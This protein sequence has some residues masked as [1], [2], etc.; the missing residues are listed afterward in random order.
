MN[1]RVIEGGDWAVRISMKELSTDLPEAS[2]DLPEESIDEDTDGKRSSK[3]SLL[4]YIA[5]E[6]K[7]K[8]F[9]SF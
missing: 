5:S 3:G 7:V 1:Q 6:T 2:T 4:F 9:G 8:C